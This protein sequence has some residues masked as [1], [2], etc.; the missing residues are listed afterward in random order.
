MTQVI[1]RYFESARKA[2]LVKQAL[3]FERFP[4]N[5][6]VVFTDATGLSD[7]LAAEHVEAKTAKAYEKRLESGGA[8]LLAKATYKP[9]GAARKTRELTAEMGAVDMGQLIEEVYVKDKPQAAATI[10]KDH[11]H[12]LT[13]DKDLAPTGYYMADWPIPLISRRKP[14]EAFLFPRHAR[15]AN[16]PI[17]LI[18]RRKPSDRFAF[19]RHARMAKFPIPLISRRKPWSEFAF[20]RHARMAKFPIPL[21]SRRKPFSGTIIGRHTRMANWPFPHLINGKTGTNALVPGGA[22]MANF[23]ISLISNRKPADK[24]AFPRHAR[25]AGFPIPLISG[26]KPFTGSIFSRHARMADAILPLIIKH[27]EAKDAEGGAGFSLSRLFGLPTLR[28]R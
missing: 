11:P 24:F 22:R 18:S 26:R 4:K 28:K 19:P 20:P 14:S 1:T 3:Q 6:L 17:P 21:I 15:M 2:Q 25:M 8:V 27:A 9:L 7:V 10:L 23:P 12:I 5:D 16:F 13:R